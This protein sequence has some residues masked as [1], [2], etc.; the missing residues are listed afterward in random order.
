MNG[1][2]GFTATA[3]ANLDSDATVDQWHVNDLKSNLTV[4]DSN[5]VSG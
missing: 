4:A 5:D 1:L 3:T 2:F